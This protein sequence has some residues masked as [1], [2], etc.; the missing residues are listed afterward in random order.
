MKRHPCL[1]SITVT[2][3]SACP[4]EPP[5]KSGMAGIASLADSEMDLTTFPTDE[6]RFSVNTGTHARGVGC[7]TTRTGE[8]RRRA[9]RPGGLQN[10][11]RKVMHREL[12][13]AGIL[14]VL[15]QLTQWLRPSKGKQ[16]ANS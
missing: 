13:R 5:S 2:G 14:A 1:R 11:E 9:L 12:A 10:P 15:K 3:R 16:D 8:G 4:W 7:G 6:L